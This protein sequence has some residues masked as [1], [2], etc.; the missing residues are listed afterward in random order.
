[1]NRT[2]T[3]LNGATLVFAATQPVLHCE[4]NQSTDGLW[5]LLFGWQRL[6]L[7]M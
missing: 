5:S 2:S 4:R 1:M 3:D 6:T 7:D